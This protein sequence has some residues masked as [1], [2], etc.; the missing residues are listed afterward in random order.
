MKLDDI[1][2][3]IADVSTLPQVA[4]R[5]LDIVNNPETSV[6]DLRSVVEGDPALTIRLLRTVN[7]AA[8]GLRTQVDSIHRAIALLGFS[9]VKNLAITASVAQMFKSD[10]VIN[11]YSRPGLWKHMI[12]VGVS[13]RLIASRSGLPQFDEAYMCGLLHDVGFVLLDQHAH[14]EFV[15][16]VTKLTAEVP[17]HEVERSTLQLDHAQVGA[18][19]AE[20]WKFPK[21][22]V[23]SIRNH[24]QSARG[25]AEHQQLVRVVE[26]ANFLCSKKGFSSMGIHNTPTPAPEVFSALSIGREDLKVLW[27]DLDKELQHID[28][29]AKI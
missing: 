9:A 8:Y 7:S 18:V 1:V 13:A 29:L 17:T 12:A 27:Q 10:Q 25:D 24:H 11:T 2:R 4:V 21:S 3:R 20:R 28:E 26:V 15:T 5:I 6:T 22:V 19:I 14:D 16:V 23:E